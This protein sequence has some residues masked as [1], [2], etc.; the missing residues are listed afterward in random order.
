MHA[1]NCRG[2][3]GAKGAGVT[4]R[5]LKRKVALSQKTSDDKDEKEIAT[6]TPGQLAVDSKSAGRT[7]AGSLAHNWDR[8]CDDNLMH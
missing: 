5:R 4:D 3:E 1:R 6:Q 7:I 2:N 8:S